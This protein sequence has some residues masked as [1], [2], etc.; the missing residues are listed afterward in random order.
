MS[1][2]TANVDEDDVSGEGWTLYLGDSVLTMNHIETGSVG[3]SV[4]SPP[5]PGM[6]VYSDSPHDMGNVADIAEMIGQFRYLMDAD[7]MLRVLMPGRSVFVHITQA[8]AQVGRDGYVGLKDFR[9][10]VISMMTENGWI[11]YGRSYH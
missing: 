3:L 1:E 5:F 9:G 8:T 2:R 11:Y 6:Y 4:F 10:D 7:H